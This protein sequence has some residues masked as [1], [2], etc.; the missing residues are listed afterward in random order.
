MTNTMPTFTVLKNKVQIGVVS[1]VSYEQ[2]LARAVGRYGRCEVVANGN[3]RMDRKGRHADSYSHGRR[4]YATPG[5]EA[6]REALIAE[7]KAR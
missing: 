5:F 6:R 7:F 1:A 4:P 2:A 3:A